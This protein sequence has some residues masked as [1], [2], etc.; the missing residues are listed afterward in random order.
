MSLAERIERCQAKLAADPRSL[1]FAQLAD[2]YRKQGR[3]EEAIQLCQEGLNHCPNYASAYMVL[4]RV[5]QEKGNLSEAREAFQWVLQIDP[6]SVQALKCLGHIAEAQHETPDALASYRMALILHPFDKEIRAAVARLEPQTAAAVEST[7]PEV[8]ATPE[9][10]HIPEAEP[11]LTEATSLPFEVAEERPDLRESEAEP[12]AT[13][14]MAGLYAEQGLYDR[15]ADIY[16]RLAADAPDREDLAEKYREALAHLEKK[17]GRT[18][19]PATE[20]T[21]QILETW[22]DVFRQLRRREK[23]RIGLVEARRD[24]VQRLAERQKDPVSVLEAWRDAFR[25]L[26]PRR[27][28]PTE[29]LEAWRDAFRRLKTAKGEGTG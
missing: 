11:V 24:T 12:L 3:L 13:E 22:R 25:R 19:A 29:L 7:A 4:G 5:Q 28:G 27:R 21:L 14:T 18:A 8:A 2:A 16:S 26:R 23:V 15:A 17:A 10:V 1:A 9:E 20:E 6:E